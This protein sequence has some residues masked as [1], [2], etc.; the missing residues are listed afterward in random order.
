MAWLDHY[1]IPCIKL[2]VAFASHSLRLKGVLIQG[3]YR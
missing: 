3:A 1:P 2:L